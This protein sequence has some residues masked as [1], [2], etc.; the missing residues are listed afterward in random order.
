MENYISQQKKILTEIK[1]IAINFKKTNKI[2]KTRRYGEGR[3][4]KLASLKAEFEC[5]HEKIL[6]Y[7]INNEE[8][9]SIYDELIKN[10][11]ETLELIQNFKYPETFKTEVEFG[12]LTD[13]ILA[14]FGSH[15]NQQEYGEILELIDSFDPQETTAAELFKNLL[16][17]VLTYYKHKEESLIQENGVLISKV[18][19]Q[20]LITQDLLISSEDLDKEIQ[21]QHQLIKNLQEKKITLYKRI[22]NLEANFEEA[23][24]EHLKKGLQDKESEIKERDERLFELKEILEQTRTLHKQTIDTL[25]RENRELKRII[26]DLKLRQTG[27]MAETLHEISKQVN[28]VVPIFTGEK[29]RHLVT[30]LNIFLSTCKMVHDGLNTNEG[31]TIFLKYV[32][33]RCRGDAYDLITRRKCDDFREFSTI[34]T[35]AYLPLK[36]VRDFKEELHRCT[37][38]PGETLTEYTE[39]FK[40]VVWDCI[41]CIEDKYKDNN[42][43][44]KK[45]MEIEAIDVFRAGLNNKS[46]RQY[47]LSNKSENLEEVIKEAIYFERVDNRYKNTVEKET[48]HTILGVEGPKYNTH[49]QIFTTNQEGY[50]EN[51]QHPYTPHQAIYVTQ[52]LYGDNYSRQN[53]HDNNYR[54]DYIQAMSSTRP[55]PH[56]F[57]HATGQYKLVGQEP[58]NR[59]IQH[60]QTEQHWGH[61]GLNQNQMAT[62]LNYGPTVQNSNG[63][64]FNGGQ[65]VKT[66]NW[67]GPQRQGGVNAGRVPQAGSPETCGY[68]GLNGHH[69][70]VCRRRTNICKKCGQM[71][72]FTPDCTKSVET[73]LFCGR[74][75]HSIEQCQFKTKWE[76]SNKQNG[77]N[78]GN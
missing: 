6:P 52:D 58:N 48:G 60:Q 26:V 13:I 43:A 65:F 28:T 31:K 68:C 21:S 78:Q 9:K 59:S 62:Q 33:T 7:A 69:Y 3:I 29:G 75:N 24:S 10:Y 8:I 54:P 4:E 74:N 57:S 22:E 36:S 49:Q 15:L 11:T 55:I 56:G 38:R 19:A 46:V 76:E 18:E 12:F 16:E 32:S 40:R 37:Q 42:Q 23:N 39:R 66:G 71:G 45:E 44:Y 51:I 35:D 73:C 30:E 27:K 41:K 70:N 14:H 47:L 20:K 64:N 17:N 1:K 61:Q 5:T 53:A 63:Y 25:E 50:R 77:S 34:L 72:H 2:N 67:N